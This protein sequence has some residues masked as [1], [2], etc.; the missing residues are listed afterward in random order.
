MSK[1]RS[2]QQA[3]DLDAMLGERVED[4]LPYLFPGVDPHAGLSIVGKVSGYREVEG[5]HGK[6]NV[7]NLVGAV[8]VEPAAMHEDGQS[9][10]IRVGECGVIVS[11]W[12]QGTL[13]PARF[14]AGAF[15]AVRYIGMQGRAKELHVFTIAESRVRDLWATSIED[16]A[17][18][19]QGAAK[20]ASADDLPF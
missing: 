17:G 13:T 3:D 14:K 6:F 4:A 11:R 16:A 19:Y 15:V 1:S 2:Q 20:R 10:R 18:T 8:I 9:R 7:C 12:I 5:E